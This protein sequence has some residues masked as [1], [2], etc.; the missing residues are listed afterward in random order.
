MRDL[1]LTVRGDRRV[2][3]NDPSPASCLLDKRSHRKSQKQSLPSNSDLATSLAQP[4]QP[5]RTRTTFESRRVER[6]Q[7]KNM[8]KERREFCEI[9]RAAGRERTEGRER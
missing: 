1:E 5:W 4:K 2:K 6:S 9:G 8:R 7:K 3:E